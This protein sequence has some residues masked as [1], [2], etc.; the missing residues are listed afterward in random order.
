MEM[1]NIYLQGALDSFMSELDHLDAQ[2]QK[3][4]EALIRESVRQGKGAML[5]NL[6]T[7]PGVGETVAQ[8]FVAEIF[9]PERFERAEE[10]CA[11]V[12]LAPIISQSGQSQGKAFLRRVGQDYFRSI[13]VQAAWASVRCDKYF[14]DFYAK[15]RSRTNLPQKAIAAVARKL[16]IVIWRVAVEN[17]AYRPA[18]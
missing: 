3:M 7:I 10:I 11:Y 6:K 18:A 8:T 9:R 15:I 16:L 12:G 1:G 14:R 5:R 2:I 4:K 17:R 13:L